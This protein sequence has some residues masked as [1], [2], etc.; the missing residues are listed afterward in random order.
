M[1]ESIDVLKKQLDEAK[2]NVQLETT[3]LSRAD[4]MMFIK[5]S[6]G[7]A[8]NK[9][10]ILNQAPLTAPLEAKTKKIK[11]CRSSNVLFMKCDCCEL[12]ARSVNGMQKCVGPLAPQSIQ[13]FLA[14]AFF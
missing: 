3:F 12:E 6:Y 5:R 13:C 14:W 11:G 4:C 8:E 10:I 2:R 1:Q 7:L 9:N